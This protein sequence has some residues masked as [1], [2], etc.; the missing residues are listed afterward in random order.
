[1]TFYKVICDS[2]FIGVGTT[3]DLRK[4]QQKHNLLLFAKED[5]SEYIIIGDKLFHDIWMN[6][7]KTTVFTCESASVLAISEEEYNTLKEAVDRSEEI[8]LEEHVEAVPEEREEA[9]ESEAEQITVE[10]VRDVKIREMSLACNKAITDGFDMELSGKILHFSLTAND[11]TN[12]TAA[13]AQILNGE[14]EIPYHADGEDYRLFSADDMLRIITAANRHK[15]YHLAYFNSLKKW[16]NA[17]VRLSNIRAVEYG[18]EI[19][20]KYQTALL[21]SFTPAANTEKE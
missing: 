3:R 17:L 9:P 7:E 15:T 10:Y 13:S 12:L 20:K 18:S 1:M 2:A 8:T 5:D 11:Q 19:P 6:P 16:V 4:H 14:S 21:Q